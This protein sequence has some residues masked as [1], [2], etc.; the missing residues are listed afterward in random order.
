MPSIK[1]K[2]KAEERNERTVRLWPEGTFFKAYERS[3]YLFVTQVR[4]YE[5][6]RQF[7]KA[8][9]QDVISIGFPQTVLASLGLQ[10]EKNVNGTEEIRLDTPLDEQQFLLWREAQDYPTPDPS[11][12]RD[13][14]LMVCAED[15][16]DPLPS[17]GR[18]RGGVI[19]SVVD[20]IR[21]FNLATATPMQCML[22]LS[23]L[24][25]ILNDDAGPV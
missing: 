17:E 23:K 24:Q 3:A 11:P 5:V 21:R 16:G 13:G 6:R 20:R 2:L 19:T 9:G 12:K 18:G 1:D 14:E 7:V 10:H 15:A 4:Q 8:A 25:Q 22:F